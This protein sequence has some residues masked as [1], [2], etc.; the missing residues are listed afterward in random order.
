MDAKGYTQDGT[1]DIRGGPVLASK[2]GKWRAA[3]TL[4]GYEA[5]ERMAYYGIASNLVVYLTTEL[6]EGTVPS[7]TNVNNWAG[8]V[9][10][11]PILGA[12]IADTYLGRFWTFS[13]ASI[14]YVM[15]MSLLTMAV[16]LKSFKPNCRNGIC[17]KATPSQ[18]AFFYSALYTIA[19]G[20]GGTKPN[21]STFGADQFDDFNPEER[22]S[23][24]SFFNWWLFS[25]YFGTLFANSGLVYIQDN[26]GWGLGYGIPTISLVVALIVFYI[27]TPRY[28]H[29][30]KTSKTAE[31]YAFKVIASA[32]SNRRVKVPSEL[33]E[34]HELGRQYYV[35]NEKRQVPHTNH[36]RFL[37]KAAL[38]DGRSATPCTVTQVE[39]TKLIFGMIIIFIV[40]LIPSTFWSDVSTIFVKQGSR[41]DRRLTSRF[42]LP[43]ASL[44]S[45]STFCMIICV[46]FYDRLFVPYLRSKTGHP[47]GITLLQRIGIGC[48]IQIIA[49]AI[50]F[51][52]ELR[53]MHMVKVLNL[54]GSSDIVPMSVL[55]QLPQYALLG[56]A[57]VFMDIGM[58]EFFYDQAPVDMQSIGTT[59]YTTANGAG[60][61][62]NSL[63]VTLV[64]RVS[65]KLNG[66][67]SWIGNNLNESHLDYF[68]CFL[69]T[70]ATINLGAFVWASKN[71]VY[72]REIIAVEDK[73]TDAE[74]I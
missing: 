39:K 51:I 64:D 17:N 4:V 23:K 65:R 44:S 53:R 11:T 42:E 67:K 48:V 6:H 50:A 15:G 33:S 31:R 9:W 34:L 70:I 10:M 45:V 61:F 56:V 29:K 68:Y 27:G 73:V 26:L 14:V 8:S 60:F 57:D 41:M 32:F 62:L 43:T 55:W 5:C 38:K 16:S 3:A 49:I 40:I 71:Y 59:F 21:I 63:L 74:D 13:A 25:A 36:F 46:P 72:K 22:Q 54:R 35:S 12:Y 24:T 52:V 19:I 30:P 69:M 37:D 58:L 20:T 66:G 47:R 28:R 1:V 18:I 2:T 7:V